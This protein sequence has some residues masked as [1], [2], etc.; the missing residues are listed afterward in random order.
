MNF[1][2]KKESKDIWLI[3]PGY[4]GIEYAKVL[5][6][7]NVEYQVLGRSQKSKIKFFKETGVKVEDNDVEYFLKKNKPPKRAIITVNIEQLHKVAS[8]LIKFGVKSL[9]IEKPGRLF[10]KDLLKL[11]KLSNSLNADVFIAYNRRFYDSVIAA[12]K[13]IKQDQGISSVF[14]DFTELSEKIKKTNNSNE[15]KQRWLIANSSHVIDLVFFLCGVPKKMVSLFKGEL[16]WHKSSSRFAGSG[17]TINNVL[18]S[19]AANWESAGR[20]SI[21]IMTKNHKL[22]FCPLESL[23][24]MK[25]NSF[26]VIDI[27][28]A[29]NDNHFK[30][31]LYNLV[32]DFIN[33][34]NKNF[35]TL[36]Q[37]LVNFKYFSKMANYKT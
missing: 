21:E 23:K 25:R 31:G 5:N 20:W 32:K 10:K 36:E 27:K 18:F 19:Y 26:D 34:N 22:I 24:I 3:G 15:I 14:F 28:T 8:K 2:I 29:K 7:L 1:E 17:I 33:D 13:I 9:L 4:I 35:C 11:Q 12:K 16:T 6:S 30:P 37:Q